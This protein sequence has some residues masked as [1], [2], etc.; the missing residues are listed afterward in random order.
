MREATPIDTKAFS[1]IEDGTGVYTW[2]TSGGHYGSST[3]RVEAR[4]NAIIPVFKEESALAPER[5]CILRGGIPI[6]YNRLAE[7]LRAKQECSIDRSKSY[8]VKIDE[9][10]TIE[11]AV[12]R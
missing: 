10:V 11:I 7:K 8:P 6:F 1:I 9:M 2:L 4:Q 12:I 5:L 3:S